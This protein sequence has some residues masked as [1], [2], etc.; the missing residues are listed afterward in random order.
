VNAALGRVEVLA[1]LSEDKGAVMTCG[2][3][4]EVYQLDD[5]DLQQILHS[6][7]RN[8]PEISLRS[9]AENG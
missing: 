7:S 2:F 5:E 6:E 9:D 8:A 4:N 3:C 1:M